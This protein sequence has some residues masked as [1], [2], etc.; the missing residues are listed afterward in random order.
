MTK[1]QLIFALGENLSRLSDAALI[2][3]GATV[4]RV[5]AERGLSLGG[6]QSRSDPHPPVEAP[7]APKFI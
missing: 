6:D 4:N 3:I 7:G 5:M 2:Q 1:E